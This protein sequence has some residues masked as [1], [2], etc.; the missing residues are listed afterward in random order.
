MTGGLIDNGQG[1]SRAGRGE[2][3]RQNAVYVGFID[4]EKAY[5]MV[6]RKGL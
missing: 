4:L 5:H 6:N 2:C 1:G 3:T